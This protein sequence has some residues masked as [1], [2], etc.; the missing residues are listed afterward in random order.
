MPRKTVSL[1][2]NAVRTALS[3]LVLLPAA[4]LADPWWKRYAPVPDVSRDGYRVEEL[5]WYTTNLCLFAFSLVVIAL[6]GFCVVYRSRPGRLRGFYYHGTDKKSLFVTG[7]LAALVFLSVD[8][9]LVRGSEKDIKEYFYNWPTSPDTFKVEVMPQQWAWNIRYAGA[10]ELFNT[11]DDVVTLNDMRVPVGRPIFVQLKAKDVIHSFY[12]P[13]FR[14]KQDAN[15][16]HVTKVWFQAKET[17]KF[18]IAC[19]QMCGWAHYKMQGSFTVL[20]AADFDRWYKEAQGDAARKFDPA[21]KDAFW[22]WAW[23][24]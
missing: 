18:E 1:A 12:L 15:P 13:N 4:A 10:D 23:E 16:G 2:R 5:F 3:S 20:G 7:S 22:G 24:K 14:I 19:S 8:M 9:R 17:G 21:D 6:V 11:A